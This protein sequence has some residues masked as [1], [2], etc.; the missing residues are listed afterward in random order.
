MVSRLRKFLLYYNV[1]KFQ[2]LTPTMITAE[3]FNTTCTNTQQTTKSNH[4][5]QQTLFNSMV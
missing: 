5:H 2:L 1:G 3:M 4:I